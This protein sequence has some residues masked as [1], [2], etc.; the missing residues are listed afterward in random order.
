M[1]QLGHFSL[2]QLLYLASTFDLL[3]QLN[4]DCQCTFAALQLYTPVDMKWLAV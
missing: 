3:M 4:D 2:T 1:L